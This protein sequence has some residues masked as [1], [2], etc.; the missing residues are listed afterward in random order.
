MGGTQAVGREFGV[1]AKLGLWSA[2]YRARDAEVRGIIEGGLS[3][4]LAFITE[5]KLGRGRVVL[6]GSM[7]QGEPG[8]N[9]L[10]SMIDHYADVASA[11]VRPSATAGTL[12]VQRETSDGRVWIIVNVN[13][14]GGSVEL[15]AYGVDLVTGKQISGGTIEIGPY[16]YSAIE[17]A[18]A[19]LPK[20]PAMANSPVA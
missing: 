10:R 3:P 2:V 16:Q 15:P 20:S 14:A 5:R 12:V 19:T 11:S 1:E 17:F 9:M 13:G 6:L 8:R 18:G 7:P 4:D